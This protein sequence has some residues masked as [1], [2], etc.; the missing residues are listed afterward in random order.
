MGRLLIISMLLL[1]ACEGNKDQ[2]D[3][4]SLPL[5]PEVTITG[6][7]E[8]FDSN[9]CTGAEDFGDSPYGCI[10]FAQIVVFSDQSLYY[11]IGADFIQSVSAYLPPDTTTS[12]RDHGLE[13][14]P[15]F[16]FRYR[17]SI[18]NTGLQ[19]TLSANFDTDND[20]SDTASKSIPLTEL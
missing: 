17:F 1:T 12:Q 15:G 8:Y 5:V 4:A 16:Y 7:Y 13:Y 19:P 3:L 9:A 6:I 2:A 18:D 11:S 14:S 20:F 10:R